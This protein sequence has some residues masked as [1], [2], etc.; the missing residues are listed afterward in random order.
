[1]SVLPVPGDAGAGN[2]A[3]LLNQPHIDVAFVSADA[4]GLAEAAGGSLAGRLELVARLSPQEVHVVARAGIESLA[5]LA[6]KK[7]NFGPTGGSSAVTATLLFKALKIAVEP[8]A[9][10]SRTAIERL[11]QGAIAASVIVGGK[12]TLII[13]DIPAGHGIHLV[14]IEFGAS[15]EDA[16][17][18][19]RFDQ[20]KQVPSIATGMVLLA[21]RSKDD[22][23]YA[24]RVGRFVDTLFSRFAELQAPGRHPKWR[25]IN[26]AAS[27]AGWTRTPAAEAWLARRREEA[28]R[29]DPT[30]HPAAISTEA[31]VASSK[32]VIVQGVHRVAAR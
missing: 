20:G 26:L 1:L 23:G 32:G 9:L 17:L 13:A 24:D 27:L 29:P 6:G 28:V 4:L 21:A 12:P 5:D 8:V 15:L 19:T 31:D 16:Y 22:P 25:E 11:Q 18:P 14:P 2:I 7:V 30:L 3:L 10:D